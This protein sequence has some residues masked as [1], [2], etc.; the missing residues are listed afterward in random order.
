MGGEDKREWNAF[1]FASVLVRFGSRERRRW[2][3]DREERPQVSQCRCTGLDKENQREREIKR[4]S[5]LKYPPSP[6]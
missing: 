5:E 6:W 2:M 1:A 3:D 4:T